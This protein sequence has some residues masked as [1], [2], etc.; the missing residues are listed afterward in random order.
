MLVK[1]EIENA[2]NTNN[3]K[4]YH[5]NLFRSLLEK[6]ANFLGY[7]KWESCITSSNK[8]EYT[9]IIDL[10]NHGTLSD[11]EYKELSEKDKNL[12]KSVFESF[13]KEFKW[14]GIDENT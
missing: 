14:N 4:K 3:I 10:Y 12:F 2:I 11:L 6:T 1:K 9:K 13:V 8:E 7:E 5:F